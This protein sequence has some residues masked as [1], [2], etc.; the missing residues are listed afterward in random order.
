[1]LKKKILPFRLPADI[2]QELEEIVGRQYIS[3]DRATVE[4]YSKLS[5]DAAG[6]LQ[7]H[8]K[9]QMNPNGI[10]NPGKLCFD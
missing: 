7:K 6:Y 2:Y 9:D 5:I 8:M 1:M 3:E 4:A 10:L